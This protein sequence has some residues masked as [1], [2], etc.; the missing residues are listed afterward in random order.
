MPNQKKFNI[1]IYCYKYLTTK[2]ICISIFI[3]CFHQIYGIAYTLV[4]IFGSSIIV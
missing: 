2:K 1:K 4:I 3:A